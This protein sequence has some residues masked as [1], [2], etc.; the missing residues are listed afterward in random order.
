MNI[1]VVFA[2]GVGRRMNSKAKPKQFL[3]ING[4]PIIIHTIEQFDNHDEIDAICIVSVKEWI[5]QVKALVKKYGIQK[6]RWIVEGGD[7]ALDSQYLGLKA[8]DQKNDNIVLLHDGVRPL[9]DEKTIS[10]CISSV[11]KFGSAV[12]IAPATETIFEQNSEEFVEKI[13]DRSRCMLARAPQCF[14]LKDILNC[15]E[16][17]ISEGNHNFIDS[18]SMMLHYGNKIHT[19]IGPSE[20]IKVTTPADFYICRALLSAKE[21]SQLYGL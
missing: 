7:T 14:Y 17:S 15:H 12:T 8:I 16:V 20:N 6:V 11:H 21:D 4:K 18:A 3:E 1:A 2:G 19:V 5:D 9:I 10:E 13:H